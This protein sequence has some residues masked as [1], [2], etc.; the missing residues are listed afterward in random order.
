MLETSS[1]G[2]IN[3]LPAEILD[4]ILVTVTHDSEVFIWNDRDIEPDKSYGRTPRLRLLAQLRLVN[5]SFH[6]SAWRAFGRILGETN[7]D[8]ESKDSMC[9]LSCISDHDKLRP[10]VK[11]LRFCCHGQM[12]DEDSEDPREQKMTDAMRAMN[13]EWFPDLWSVKHIEHMAEQPLPFETPHQVDQA[14]TLIRNMAHRLSKLRASIESIRYITTGRIP[15]RYAHI[16]ADYFVCCDKNSARSSYIKQLTLEILLRAL[17]EAGVSPSYLRLDIS[18]NNHHTFY[19]ETP[20]ALIQQ[21]MCRVKKLRLRDNFL[22]QAYLAE[23]RRARQIVLSKHLFPALRDLELETNTYQAEKDAN[24]TPLPAPEHIMPLDT[25]IAL[26]HTDWEDDPLETLSL[27]A[28]YTR[29][30]ILPDYD[31][32]WKALLSSMSKLPLETLR[33]KYSYVW[34]T[35]ADQDDDRNRFIYMLD[36]VTKET[37]QCMPFEVIIT[38]PKFLARV[39]S[40]FECPEVRRDI[41]DTSSDSES[42]SSYVEEYYSEYSY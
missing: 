29:K 25:F 12:S 30:L 26:L 34:L 21:A 31:K 10:W 15:P 23:G 41:Y 14:R 1:G 35:D 5:R 18:T 13:D 24:W 16:Y 42:I 19:C 33:L 22:A 32:S 40:H 3:K 20:E 17:A 2:P 4:Q 38:P 8:I 6:D 27:Y 37:L 28:K 36:G 7:F 9:V 11:H 39:M